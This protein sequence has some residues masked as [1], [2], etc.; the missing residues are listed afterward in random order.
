MHLIRLYPKAGM[1]ERQIKK[2]KV[3]G[4]GVPRQGQKL[5]NMRSHIKTKEIN[6]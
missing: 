2:N 5:I 1:H 4:D 6:N 3:N